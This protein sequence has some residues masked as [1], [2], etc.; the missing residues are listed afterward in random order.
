MPTNSARP[1]TVAAE[2]GEDCVLGTWTSI[3]TSIQELR[4]ETE[5]Y[6]ENSFAAPFGIRSPELTSRPPVA[7]WGPNSLR[8]L[9][10]SKMMVRMC[11]TVSAL[12]PF[13]IA[14]CVPNCL[15][16]TPS[17]MLRRP[18]CARPVPPPVAL[19]AVCPPDL[20]AH[21]TRR[22]ARLVYTPHA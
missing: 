1:C 22:P 10:R 4:D 6:L 16:L 19:H 14:C 2:R 7:R 8:A 5:H 20:S 18:K 21:Q 17:K 9:P 3:Y 15:A 13:C 11:P 12:L